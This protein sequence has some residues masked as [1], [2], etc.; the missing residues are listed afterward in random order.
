MMQVRDLADLVDVQVQLSQ[1]FA[2]A[3][4]KRTDFFDQVVTHYQTTK[5]RALHATLYGHDLVHRDVKMNQ[6]PVG[7]KCRHV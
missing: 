1:L 2:L 6:L 3:K 5:V 4:Q 7:C